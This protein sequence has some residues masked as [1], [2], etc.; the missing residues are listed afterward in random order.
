MLILVLEAST[1]SAKALL[2]DD[3]KGIVDIISKPFPKSINDGITHDTEGI[4]SAVMEV[5]RKI[6]A[7]KDIDAVALCSTWHSVVVCDSNMNPLTRTYLWGHTG[8]SN[9]VAELRKD[10]YQVKKMYE[11]TG[12]MVHALYPAY[13]LLHFRNQGL[14]LK[15]KYIAGE[16]SYLF[17]RMTGERMVTNSMASGSGMFN[18][19]TLDYDEKALEMV[20]LKTSQLGELCTY[21][22]ARPL[23]LEAANSLGISPGI[24]VI[25]THPDGALNQV[26]AGALK[27]GIMSLSVG[28]SAALRLSSSKPIVSKEMGT[29][30]YLSPT[31]WLAGAATSGACNCLDWGKQTFF[32]KSTSYQELENQKVDMKEIPVFLPFMFG[33][34]CPG[35]KDDRLSGF[36][37]LR[38]NHTAVD[39]YFGVLEGIVMNIRQCF[40]HITSEMGIP[41]KIMVSGGI[42][43]STKWLQMMSDILGE[44]LYCS[45]SEQASVLGGAIL[46]RAYL[47]RTFNPNEYTAEVGKVIYPNPN[48]YDHYSN[49]YNRY[50]HWYDRTS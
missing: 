31:S 8:A 18:I 33:E 46:A 6:A 14:D 4:Y 49:R 44:R 35:W 5:G 40:D 7:Q 22:D 17:Y 11:R 39:M 42:N 1:T 21:Q 50:L 23:S 29:W 3:S 16:G 27:E 26:G 38:S 15:D 34:R 45:D 43:K 25:P 28:T 36:H 37:E 2:Y 24:P 32:P 47:D 20:D 19:H 30:C 41:E 13:K 9:E 10:P 48:M 12:C